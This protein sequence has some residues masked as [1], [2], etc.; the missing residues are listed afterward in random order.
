MLE[1]NL[2][3]LLITVIMLQNEINISENK[4]QNGSE[5]MYEKWTMDYALLGKTLFTLILSNAS[6]Q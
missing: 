5:Y 2:C 3:Q 4:S 1:Y 6:S